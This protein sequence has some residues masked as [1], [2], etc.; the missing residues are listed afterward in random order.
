MHLNTSQ[1]IESTIDDSDSCMVMVSLLYVYCSD[2]NLVNVR[3]CWW[4]FGDHCD[5][6]MAMS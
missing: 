3:A 2:D 4:W 5:L 6:V 1:K